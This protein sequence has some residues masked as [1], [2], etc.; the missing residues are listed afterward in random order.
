MSEGSTSFKARERVCEL[1]RK[2][3]CAAK[4]DGRRRFHS[5]HDKIWRDDVLLVAWES[6]RA[7]RGAGGVDQVTIEVIEENG[8]QKFLDEIKDELRNGTYRANKVR[9]VYIPKPDGKKRPL[10]IPTIKDR[11][12]QAAVRLVIEPIFEADFEECS[13]GFRPNRS[14]RDASEAI[15]KWLNFG[16]VNVLDADIS[17]YFDSIPHDRLME[18]VSRRIVDGYILAL[19]RAWLRSGV[20]EEGKVY[21]TDKGTPQGGVISPLLANIYLHQF[22]KK[23]GEDGMEKKY[24]HNAHLVRYADDFVILTSKPMDAPCNKVKEIMKSLGLVLKEEKTRIVNARDGFDFLG[25]RFVRRFSKK[26]GKDKTYIVP[27]H[28]SILRVKEKIK[29]A[30][31]KKLN[32]RNKPEVVVSR[33]NLVLV[34]WANYFAH[35]NASKAFGRVQQYCENRF[36]RYLRYRRH[37]YGR[38]YKEIPDK[39]LYGKL[40]LE[41]IT[42]GRIH[43]VTTNAVSEYY[44]TAV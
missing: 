4:S 44:W 42:R 7:N 24:G 14:P 29:E 35:V 6:V 22:D 36:R 16:C 39:F 26:Y 20:L 21:Y 11:V 10:G 13:Y 5:L 15:Y 30:T 23:W 38:G 19:I 41:D 1:Q 32:S 18:Q 27:S 34:G 31:D 3:C 43:Y 17:A 33:I 8:V 37:K 2:L 12:V 28:K 40:G 9:R 25:F